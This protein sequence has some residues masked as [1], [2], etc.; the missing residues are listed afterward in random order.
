[1][2][3]SGAAELNAAERRLVGRAHAAVPVS[4]LYSTVL[5]LESATG[6]AIRR[7]WRA[8]ATD[9]A[10]GINDDLAP[11]YHTGVS[12]SS[13]ELIPTREVIAHFS[14]DKAAEALYAA[15]SLGLKHLGVVAW[16]SG[17]HRFEAATALLA[18]RESVRLQE[19]GTVTYAYPR[20][21]GSGERMFEPSDPL[22]PDEW[23]LRNT[24]QGGG[25]PG[26]DIA[27]T[28]AWDTVRGYTH[29][30]PHE[31]NANLACRIMLQILPNPHA[32]FGDPTKPADDNVLAHA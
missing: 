20:W 25:T 5:V 15:K 23:H 14:K 7:D 28:T 8:G 19:S 32:F 31:T 21:L 1:M 2:L 18:V 27:A 26:E 22:F 17:A 30:R 6:S 10:L 11:V 12:P 3:P 13:P 4:P 16:D 29:L 24:G 9:R